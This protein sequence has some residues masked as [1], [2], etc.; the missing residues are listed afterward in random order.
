MTCRQVIEFLVDYVEGELPTEQRKTFDAHLADCSEC[1]RYLAQYKTTVELTH[2]IGA[3]EEI[4]KKV[5]AGL[6]QAIVKSCET[7]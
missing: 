2:A 7:K 6:L 1:R 4:P 5:P 3:E